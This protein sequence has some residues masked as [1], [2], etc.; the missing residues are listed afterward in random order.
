M[1]LKL[2]ISTMQKKL[3]NEILHSK[4]RQTKLLAMQ[5]FNNGDAKN[6]TLYIKK[7]KELDAQCE[8]FK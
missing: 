6:A 7:L 2:N 5:A 3:S 4:I 8:D 1:G